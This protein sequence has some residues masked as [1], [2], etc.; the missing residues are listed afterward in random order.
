MATTH[1]RHEAQLISAPAPSLSVDRRA[2]L[3]RVA[4]WSR[5]VAA[6]LAAV[7][8]ALVVGTQLAGRD[9]MR[10]GV[11]AFGVDLS[12]MSREQARSALAVAVRNRVAQPLALTDGANAWQLTGS[13]LGLTMN[14]DAAVDDA[15]STGRTGWGPS[16]LALL[17]RLRGS[18]QEAGAGR[19]AVDS[20]ALDAKLNTLAEAIRQSRVDPSLTLTSDTLVSYV[21]A[22]VGRTLDVETTRQNILAALAVGDA[23]APL[24]V[25]EDRP[26]AT[27]ADYAAV[28]AQLAAI[29]DAPIQLVAADETWKLTP[30][31]LASRLTVN[32][33]TAGAPATLRADEAWVNAVVNEIRIGTDRLPRGARVW[34]DA[35][36]QLTKLED[37]VAGQT[38][39]TDKAGAMIM[40]AV[41][42]NTSSNRIDLPIS[43]QQPA[44][45]PAD[46]STLG[47]TDL[48]AESTTP[49]G[50]SIPERA[51]NIE[52][53]ARRLNGALILPGETFSFNAEIGHTTL[54]A[55]FQVAYGIANNNGS[56]STVPSVAGGICQ[57]ATTVFQPVFWG[58]YQIDVRSTHS[59]WIANYASNGI[60]GLDA[61]VDEATGLDFKWTNNSPNAVLLSAVADGQ[62]FTVKLLGTPPNW[63]VEVDPPVITD[64]VPA[65][66]TVDY[67]PSASIPDGAMRTVERASDGFSTTIVRR[68][69]SGDQ[70]NTWQYDETYGTARN[71]VLVGSSTGKLPADFVP[72]R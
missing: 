7:F 5:V 40:G 1:E 72:P 64:V 45:L 2:Q 67:Q 38:L 66:Q 69:Y 24:A 18:D 23:S 20:T 22:R 10:A 33:P 49:Y 56:L 11:R 51:N 48:I 25:S 36:G 8:I 3:R 47:I 37:S 57:V 63:R 26:A 9:E 4:V 28:R 21:N 15:W 61:T 35:N 60:V 71:V 54:D 6:V 39:D 52:L 27:D 13:D 46:L 30:D 19:V 29:L 14:V 58:G 62:N 12:G 50:G 43:V 59:Y 65:D 34:W 53:A 70:V 68:V 55:G 16:R 41:L 31:V 42:G 17:W 44:A 32:A